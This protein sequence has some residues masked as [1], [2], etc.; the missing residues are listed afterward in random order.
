MRPREARRHMVEADHPSTGSATVDVERRVAVDQR[1]QDRQVGLGH[2]DRSVGARRRRRRRGPGRSAAVAARDRRQPRRWPAVRRWRPPRVRP[3]RCRPPIAEARCRAGVAGRCEPAR[4]RPPDMSPTRSTRS[5]T[6][7]PLRPISRALIAY[8][9]P[10]GIIVEHRCEAST[11]DGRDHGFEL[12]VWCSGRSLLRARDFPLPGSHPYVVLVE[13]LVASAH[14]LS[15]G[16]NACVVAMPQPRTPMRWSRSSRSR[17]RW[18]TSRCLPTTTSLPPRG[19]TPS[20]R[21][22]ADDA[23]EEAPAERQLRV[24]RW[25][26]VPSWAKDPS[27]GSRMIN[28]RVGDGRREA[29]VPASLR[30]ASV[31]A[32]GRRLLRVVHAH[33]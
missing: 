2:D 13:M 27:I 14:R 31:P 11:V 23:P 25:G 18:S 26:L 33:R 24:V 21:V 10:V 12:D 30:Q 28:A 32:P 4:R 16:C 3:G 22:D 15:L 17:S 6:T 7:T 9:Q 5:P 20:C 19:C 1:G 8:T 29:G